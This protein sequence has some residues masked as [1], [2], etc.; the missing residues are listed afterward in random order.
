MDD[1]RYD[2]F[3]GLSADSVKLRPWL[4]EWAD[5]ETSPPAISGHAVW[6]DHRS[7]FSFREVEDVWAQR[8]VTVTCGT[9]RHWCHAQ[10][11]LSARGLVQNPFRVRCHLRRAVTIKY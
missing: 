7:C 9:I 2:Q 10:R 5:D 8:G 3:G 6:L 11:F 1:P 4:A